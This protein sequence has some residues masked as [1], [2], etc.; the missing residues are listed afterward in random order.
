MGEFNLQTGQETIYKKAN[1]VECVTE[2][3]CKL[4]DIISLGAKA[5]QVS[6][7]KETDGVSYKAKIIFNIVY[8]LE[9]EIRRKEFGIELDDKYKIQLQ[10][11]DKISVDLFIEG[12]SAKRGEKLTLQGVANAEIKVKSTRVDILLQDKENCFAR[13]KQEPYS[14]FKAEVKNSFVI[15]D[16]LEVTR[17]LKNVLYSGA[18]A[19]I[20]N[21]QCGLGSIICDGEIL[22]S[23]A[24][25]PNQEKSDIIKETRTIPFRLELEE[26]SV[27]INDISCAEV[28]V[29]NLAIKVTVQEETEKTNLAS[30]IEII[31]L[32]KAYKCENVS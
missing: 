17:P 27:S 9:G 1:S 16:E 3:A 26:S 30:Q 13:L 28:K 31:I 32:A 22:L 15:D 8:L 20:L 11:T 23:L 24:L 19:Q 6:C 4:G 18:T 10:E 21:C 14:S 5:T 29:N 2:L 7:Q 12:V 25:L